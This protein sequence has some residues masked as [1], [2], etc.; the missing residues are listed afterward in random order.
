MKQYTDKLVPGQRW[1]SDME[2]ELGLGSLET[3]SDRSIGIFFRAGNCFRE[4]S[5]RSS[6]V[7]RIVFNKGDTI[8]SRDNITITIQDIEEKS[9]IIIYHGNGISIPETELADT[10]SFTESKQRIIGGYGDPIDGFNLRYNVLKT[11]CNHKK[12]K[13]YGFLGGRV[14]L[15]SHQFYIAQEISS[16]H[17]PRVLLADETGLGKTIEAGLVLHRLLLSERINRVLILVPDSLVHQWFVELYRRFNMVFTIFNDEFCVDAEYENKNL[18]FAAQTGI[19]SIDWI[20]SRKKYW[21]KMIEAD[22]DMLVIDEAHHIEEEKD[23]FA[24]I[25]VLSKKVKSMMLLSATP[26]KPGLRGYFSCLQLLDPVRFHD[27]D[28]FCAQTKSFIKIAKQIDK[29]LENREDDESRS[30]AEEILDRYGPGRIIFRN[31]RSKIKGFPE[32]IR[33]LRIFDGNEKEIS[34]VNMEFL[35]ETRKNK[36]SYDFIDDVKIKWLIDFL[37]ADKKRKV[38]LICKNREKAIAID[39]AIDR[40]INIKKALFHES[41]SLMQ[42]DRNAAWF[43]E[44]NGA[45]LLICSEIGSEGRNFQFARHLVMFDLPCNPELIEQRIGRIDRIG[46][47]GQI[48]IHVLCIKG[49]VEEIF[50]KWYDYGLN[51]FKKNI[52]GAHF[53]FKKFKEEL[54]ILAEKRINGQDFSAS[55]LKELIHRTEI[56]KNKISRELEKG[57]DRL[58]ELNSFRPEK[59]DSLIRTIKYLDQDCRI[60]AFILKLFGHFNIEWENMENRVFKLSFEHAEESGFPIPMLKR[61]GMTITFNR[62]IAVTRDDM[63][64]LTL[65]HPMVSSAMELILGTG[66]G[67][68]CFAELSG[69]G[70]HNIL[71]ESVFILEV[72]ADKKLYIDKFMPIT[73]IRIVV[74][75][76]NTGDF[77]DIA[78]FTDKYSF[79]FFKEN[80]ASISGAWIKKIPEISDKCIPD[81]FQKSGDI[82]KQKADAII[83][84]GANKARETI[85]KE[86]ARL[87]YLK[88]INPAVRD[89]EIEAA[90]REMNLIPEY[91]LNAGLRL[92]AARLIRQN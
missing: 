51:I 19:C 70:R 33:H 23:F 38:L 31:T 34:N 24:F 45:R 7:K 67:N 88:K 1:A 61:E 80:L 28:R 15:I 14:E 9:G 41:L 20:F 64:F 27:F 91:I 4:Y 63:E 57:R 46:Q 37:K 78:D 6:P 21:D 39:L 54:F 50:V 68:S 52:S 47:T 55:D 44:E 5:L 71:L 11:R 26:E 36:F 60:D 25:K 35:W 3:I 75:Y 73:P 22:W 16:R 74:G 32:R 49:S 83:E 81:L 82:A 43:S 2:P 62:N 10:I 58:L 59:A 90:R 72:M 48:H 84:S 92:D 53:I 13:A 17:M 86:I 77:S 87:V 85:K 40:R 76:N 89:S 65:D 79:D 66:Y 69:T 42:R 30:K 18:F 12:S 56:Y 29:I 8:K